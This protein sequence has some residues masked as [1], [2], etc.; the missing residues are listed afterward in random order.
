LPGLR[1]IKFPEV[2]VPE[3]S[4]FNEKFHQILWGEIMKIEL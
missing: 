2:F 3:D 4:L 1:R